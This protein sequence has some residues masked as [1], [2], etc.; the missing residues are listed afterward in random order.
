MYQGLITLGATLK[1]T[2]ITPV[3]FN[4]E[5]NALIT[6]DGVFNAARTAKQMASNLFKPADVALS[7]WL[8]VTRNILAGRFGNRWSTMWAQAG[9]TNSTTAV[10]TR[11]ADRLSL[12]LNLANFFTANPSFEVSS[13]NVTAAQAT[14][15]RNSAMTAQEALTAADVLLKSKGTVWDDAYATLTTTMRALINILHATLD[16]TD[17]RWLVFGLDMPATNTTPGQPENVTVSIDDFGALVVQC[18]AVALAVR[19]RWRMLIVGIE[20][21]YRLVARSVDPIGTIPGVLPGQTVE[22]IVQAVNMGG[23][24]GVPSEPIFFT[25]PMVA[26]PVAESR[27]NAADAP[28]ATAPSDAVVIPSKGNG[29]RLPALD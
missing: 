10:P 29:S 24:Q 17:P 1:I 19:Y 11:I 25:V 23:S 5:L 28:V 20:T 27:K 14:L 9:F 13:M 26:K 2:Q 8:Q 6:A 4:T 12:G 7:D 3:E 15:L 18:G 16:D 21:D 22:I